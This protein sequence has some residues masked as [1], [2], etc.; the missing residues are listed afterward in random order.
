MQS[1]TFSL[2]L[3][4][5]LFAPLAFGTVET[6]SHGILQ[7][8][9]ALAS[10][11]LAV[12]LFRRKGSTLRIPGRLPLFLLAGWTLLQLLPL[13]VA[14]IR[15][16]TPT[17][18]EMYRPLLEVDPLIRWLPLTLHPKATLLAFCR[19]TSFA[20]FYLLTVQL[21][22]EAR[23]LKPAVTLIAAFSSLLAVESILQKLTSPEAIFWFRT[24]PASAS[25]IGPWVYSNQFAGFMEMVFPLVIALFLFYRPH[26]HYEITF[27]DRIIALFTLPGAN[28]YLLLGTGAVLIAVAILLSLS[29]GGIITLC[30]AFLFIAFLSIRVTPD[31]QV[32]WGI[33]ISVSVILMITWFGWQPIMKE[34]GSLWEGEVLQTSGRLPLFKDGMKIFADFPLTGTGIG[35][36]RD[37]YPAYRSMPGDTVYDHAHNDYLELLVEGGLIGFFLGSWFVL[38][39]IDNVIGA[40]LRRREN[41]SVLITIGALTGMLALLLHCFI[42][43][44]LA[45][46]ANALYFFFICGLAVSGA[47]TRLHYQTRSTFLRQ[48]PPAPLLLQALLALAVLIGSAWLNSGILRASYAVRD[49][50]AVYLNQHLPLPRLQGIHAQLS[51]AARLDPLEEGYRLRLGQVSTL[52]QEKGQAQAEYLQACRRNPMAGACIQQLGLVLSE[53]EPSRTDRLLAWGLE[54]EPRVPERHLLYSKWLL[55]AGSREQAITVL[56]RAILAVPEGMPDFAPFLVAQGFSPEELE[57]ILPRRADAWF[58]LGRTMETLNRPDAAAGYYRK[59]LDYLDNGEAVADYF[60]RPYELYRRL[61]QEEQALAI[62]RQ[63]IL[64]LPD[65]SWFRI[66]L[67]DH[68]AGAGIGYRAREEYLQALRNDPANRE[69][70]KKIEKLDESRQ[71]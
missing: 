37:V 16:L 38:S 10:L 35:T 17:T 39:V 41:Y 36:F 8:T 65:H 6:W 57:R 1:L 34:F 7:F 70:K 50:H 15:F 31:R 44:Q 69:L 42:D 59:A 53:A 28:R 14:A 13:P 32:R 47:N 58:A 24:A 66:Q 48:Q 33:V 43:F 64:A 62:L 52:M 9:V 61:Q 46:G 4:V 21:L 2:F 22:S 3:F 40:L 5:L 26:V 25:P 11:L 56:S 20:L 60:R 55:A 29:R 63:G 68:Y 51:A 67:G 30:L 27:R 71:P 49:L 23:R 19:W 12:S 54:R 45:S 18:Y